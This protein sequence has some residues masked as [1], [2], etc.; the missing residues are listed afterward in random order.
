MP[1]LKSL[2][3]VFIALFAFSSCDVTYVTEVAPMA[4]VEVQSVV[5]L[6]RSNVVNYW[7]GSQTNITTDFD[8]HVQNVGDGDARNVEMTLLLFD[9]YNNVHE[10]RVMM[11]YLQRF[12]NGTFHV[13]TNMHPNQITSHE[14]QL[15]WND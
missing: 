14:V 2:F 10:T 7:W 4:N 9:Q 12:Y 6:E 8:I 15:R 5:K 3:L 11:N 1:A 13:Q